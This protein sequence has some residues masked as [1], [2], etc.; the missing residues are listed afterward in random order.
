MNTHSSFF[1]TESAPMRP[2]PM[3]VPAGLWYTL[4]KEDISLMSSSNSAGDMFVLGIDI[5]GR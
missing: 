3:N 1:G 5:G 4:A 2:S